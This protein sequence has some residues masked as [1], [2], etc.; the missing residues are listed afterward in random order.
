LTDAP[1][2]GTARRA[3]VAASALALASACL[4]AAVAGCGVGEGES[5]GGEATLTV[6]TDYGAN[7][8]AEATAE[9]SAS[10]TVLRFLDRET[11]IAT[12]YGGGFVQS[13]DGL[14]GGSEGG[15]RL[16]WFFYVNGVES[17]VGAAEVDV[18]AGDR[19]WWDH[20]DW[21]D[22][23]RVPAVVGS[24][25]APFSTS[26]EAEVHCEADRETCDEVASRTEGAG[27]A[28]GT[29]GPLVLVGT[30]AE[31][32][33]QD[34]ARP[35]ARGPLA[36]GVFARF[37][38]TGGRWEL[39]ALDETLAERE[40][41]AGGAGLVAA[42][43][44]GEGDPTWIVTGTDEGGVSAAANLLDAASLSGHFAVA[45]PPDADP[46]PLPVQ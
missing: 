44:E 15:R 36:S 26:G 21:T 24:W 8:V 1:A 39:L 19:I 43:T 25:P 18:A 32:R 4:A 40:R 22:V 41:L 42:V 46:F 10:E 31:I 34:A 6:T 14:S 29:D 20:H 5:S 30:W 23:M 16:D 35:L 33:R 7:R 2:R 11:E 17:S 28:P 9:P 45:I 27:A 12:R 3:R 13:I 38:E 37:E